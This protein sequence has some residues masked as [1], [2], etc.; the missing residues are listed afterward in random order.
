[1]VHVVT[2]AVMVMLGSLHDGISLLEQVKLPFGAV[3]VFLVD[4]LPRLPRQVQVIGMLPSA[5]VM[6]P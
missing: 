6:A 2:A 4:V 5:G 3:V 1:M